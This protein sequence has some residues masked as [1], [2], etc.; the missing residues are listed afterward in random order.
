MCIRAIVSDNRV[1]YHMATVFSTVTGQE[2]KCT[3]RRNGYCYLLRTEARLSWA[4]AQTDCKSFGGTLA[5]GYT[6][7]S[8]Q[9]LQEILVNNGIVDDSVWTGAALENSLDLTGN[10]EGMWR[11]VTGV[12]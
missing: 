9:I 5:A 10:P 7:S 1:S 3:E 11:W 12:L 4:D 8:Q 6:S 2:L